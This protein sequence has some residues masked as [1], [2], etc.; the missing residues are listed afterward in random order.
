MRF[1][2]NL[3]K[4]VAQST[5]WESGQDD[6]VCCVT[7]ECSHPDGSKAFISNCFSD[8]LLC[9]NVLVLQLSRKQ[10]S[11]TEDTKPLPLPLQELLLSNKIGNCSPGVGNIILVVLVPWRTLRT[12]F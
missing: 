6:V 12:F 4:V 1:S 11:L 8:P 5:F 2:T 3:F 7:Y 9:A 10:R